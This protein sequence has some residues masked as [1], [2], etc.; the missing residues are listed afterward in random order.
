MASLQKYS[1]K[2]REYYRIVES[3]R[4]NGKSR[5]IPI[6][7]IGTREDLIQRLLNPS[8]GRMNTRSFQHGD[9]ACL[10][11]IADRLD[12]VGIIDRHVPR[13]RRSLSVGTSFLLAAINRAS[14]PV[15]K[16]AW[17]D[18]AKGTSIEKFFR[19]QS[20]QL[21]SQHFW[22]QMD[23]VSESDLEAIEGEITAKII[24]EF[25][26]GLDTI[27]YDTT[28][29]FT[30]IAT[31]NERSTLTKRG[32]NKQK[33]SDLRQ[34]GLGLL[35]SRD[36]G[37]PLCS[38]VYRGN[39]HDS[40]VFPE[41]LTRI[42]KRLECIAVALEELTLVYDKG[43]NSK[44]NQALVDGQ[45][46]HYVGSLVP[47][48]H[49]DLL[50]IPKADYKPIGE[51]KLKDVPVYRCKKV[52][53]GVERTL[54]LFVS[55][56]LLRGQI[57][58][59]HQHLD[60]CLSE[61]EQWKSS[62]AKPGSGP[63]T[64]ENA[65]KKIEELLSAQHM[66]EVLKVEYNPRRKG[67]S[68]LSWKVDQERV[69]HLETEVFGKRILM[70]DRHHWSSEEI[71]VAYR[72]QSKAESNFKQG[73]DPDHLAVRPQYHWTDQKVRVHTFI[74]LLALMLS[75]LLEREA[76][77]QGYEHCLSTLLDE[78]ATIR[79]ALIVTAGTSKKS[80]VDCRWQLEEAEPDILSLFLKLV[81]D[82]EPFVY[83]ALNS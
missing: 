81:P 13:R 74:C 71:I 28:N 66:K 35:V 9:V 25:N 1:V 52:I 2:G 40:K 42:R 22:D 47:T 45:E 39:I 76:R 57:A 53:W 41:S 80:P 34:F 27:F 19:V 48:Q 16:R 75:C 6:L 55:E 70:T 49:E 8:Q 56:R 33:R 83:T 73:K 67:S 32:K 60:K 26:I 20:S 79:L 30:Y 12:V 62:L 14:K 46:F 38:N 72:G 44:G 21:T 43:N 18:W 29:F 23:E 82:R 37:I 54:V 61:L 10:K 31:G 50:S 65:Q 64:V 15:S 3:R 5:P 63:N 36:G 4:I 24:K 77:Q 68:R 7:H 51:G 59:L 17:I 69:D 58:G 11:S 78:L